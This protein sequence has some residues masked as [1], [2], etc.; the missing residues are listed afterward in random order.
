MRDR[1]SVPEPKYTKRQG[2]Y[3]AF[4]H[5]YTVV[6]NRPPS[7]TDIQAFFGVTPPSV[8]QMVVRLEEKGLIK[9][10]PRQ[11]RTIEVLV[12]PEQLPPLE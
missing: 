8:H 7:E 2:Q 11:A 12:P 4:I 5:H 6:Q 10:V 9:R 1:A 3:L